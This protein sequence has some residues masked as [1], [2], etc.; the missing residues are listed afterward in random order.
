MPKKEKAGKARLLNQ[1]LNSPCEKT[2]LTPKIKNLLTTF[3]V[4]NIV[5]LFEN[6]IVNVLKRVKN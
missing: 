4:T 3:Y 5:F 1:N 6:A 2:Q